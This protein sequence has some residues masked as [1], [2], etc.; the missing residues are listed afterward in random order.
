MEHIR[1]LYSHTKQ[2]ACALVPIAAQCDHLLDNSCKAE[3][4]FNK[5]IAE[6]ISL[7]ISGI[8]TCSMRSAR[9]K[10]Q[11]YTCWTLSLVWGLVW[12]MVDN[13]VNTSCFTQHAVQRL[14][15]LTMQQQQQN[16]PTWTNRNKHTNN[17]SMFSAVFIYSCLRNCVAEVQS[18]EITCNWDKHKKQNNKQIN[19][20]KKQNRN[21][22]KHNKQTTTKTTTHASIIAIHSTNKAPTQTRPL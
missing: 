5:F 11:Q 18:S 7:Q 9:P 1:C 3:T 17:I 16:T 2:I 22:Q 21:K 4:L 10:L 8:T 20:I 6:S 19:T 13:H 15:N 12:Q 14:K